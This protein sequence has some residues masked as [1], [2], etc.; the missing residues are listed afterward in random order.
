MNNK[1]EL[2]PGIYLSLYIIRS[3][4]AEIILIKREPTLDVKSA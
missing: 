3:K 2:F 1:Y 4:I